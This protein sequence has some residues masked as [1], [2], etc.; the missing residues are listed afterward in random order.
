MT[1]CNSI[2]KMLNLLQTISIFQIN[3]RMVEVVLILINVRMVEVVLILTTIKR[4]G[5]FSCPLIQQIAP[6]FE[7][8][9]P[10]PPKTICLYF[11]G[12]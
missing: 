1:F 5:M 7:L 12:D 10:D 4:I 11:S 2:V 3:V 8:N 9:I 6:E